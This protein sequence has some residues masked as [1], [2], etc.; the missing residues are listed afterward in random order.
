MK[1]LTANC[2][3]LNIEENESQGINVAESVSK[4]V[5][6]DQVYIVRLGI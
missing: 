3:T 6:S 5:E 1:Y 2:V 4:I